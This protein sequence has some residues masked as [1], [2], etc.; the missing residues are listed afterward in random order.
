MSLVADVV[1]P[2]DVALVAIAHLGGDA[3]GLD[4]AVDAGGDAGVGQR[5]AAIEVG[6]D[7]LGDLEIGMDAGAG[8]RRAPLLRAAS[9][10]LS[11]SAACSGGAS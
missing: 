7:D 5:V 8:T 10:W 9:G 11:S 6:A 1:V 2:F 4:A 3:A